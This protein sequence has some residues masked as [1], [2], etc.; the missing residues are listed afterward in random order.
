MMIREAIRT[1]AEFV[2]LFVFG[3]ASLCLLFGTIKF[4]GDWEE[5]FAMMILNSI[6]CSFGLVLR[7]ICGRDRRRQIED[8]RE[9][10]S[11]RE[12]EEQARSE[13]E[14]QKRENERLQDCRRQ[15][16][17]SRRK[18]EEE[19]ARRE[20][21]ASENS[22]RER[23]RSQQE[24]RG[25]SRRSTIRDEKYYG[26]ILGLKGRVTPTDVKQKYREL[27]AQYHPDKVSHLGP[28]LRAVADIEMKAINEAYEYFKNKYNM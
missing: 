1:S 28:K 17:S 26:S 10:R 18:A 11:R 2:G 12:K 19:R 3:M 6:F 5:F 20:D 21:E 9:K 4:W 13:R 8:D 22:K 15:R 25:N 23:S 16:E 14:R 24:D 27:C 7:A